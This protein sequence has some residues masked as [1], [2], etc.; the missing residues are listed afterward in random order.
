M[1]NYVGVGIY[2]V[3]ML[4]QQFSNY[5]SIINQLQEICCT[6]IMYLKASTALKISTFFEKNGKMLLQIEK[7]IFTRKLEEKTDGL[8]PCTTVVNLF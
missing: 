7:W 8:S 4:N 1:G 6:Q 2:D 3:D 5:V